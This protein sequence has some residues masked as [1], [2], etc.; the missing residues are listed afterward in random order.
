MI[1]GIGT[2]LV[3]LPRMER[4]VQ[5]FG[6]RFAN[7]ILVAQEQIAFK[8][9]PSALFLAKHFAV[10]EAAAKALGTGI[11]HGVSFQDFWVTHTV[12]G[13]P[14]LQMSPHIHKNFALNGFLHT[15][16]SITDEKDRVLAFVIFEC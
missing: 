8:K 3:Y 2:D 13:K 5:K 12:H 4:I 9:K 10:K 14:I 15:H 6:V 7:R 16:L 11:A 1:L